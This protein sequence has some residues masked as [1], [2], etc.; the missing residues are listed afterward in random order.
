MI[1]EPHESF[2]GVYWIIEQSQRFLAT[3]SLDPRTSVYGERL[4]RHGDAEY[5]EWIPYRSKLAAAI[6]TGLK[7]L[8]IKPSV[9]VLYLGSATGTTVS[10]VSD[11]VGHTGIVFAV[12]FAPRVMAQFIERVARRR[13]NIIPILEDARLPE[14]YRAF[15]GKVDVVYC[16]VAQPEQAK[17]LIDNC[18]TYLKKGGEALLAVKARSIDSTEDPEKVFRREISILEKGGLRVK[19]HV[20][21]E[22]YEEDHIMVRVKYD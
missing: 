18:I 19:E 10:H 16:D 7:E 22:P 8:P 20:R 14:R 1:I 6:L 15:V 13:S 12:D 2:M 3:K 4:F 5:R 17:L 11:I 21:L 9:R